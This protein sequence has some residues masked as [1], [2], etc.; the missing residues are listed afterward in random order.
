MSSCSKNFNFGQ[1]VS[2]HKCLGSTHNINFYILKFFVS[3]GSTHGPYES[4]HIIHFNFFKK[5]VQYGLTQSSYRSTHS[6]F[7]R[8]IIFSN[9]WSGSLETWVDPFTYFSFHAPVT[10]DHS[11]TPLFLNFSL[12][13]SKPRLFF[14]FLKKLHKISSFSFSKY[15]LSSSNF[16]FLV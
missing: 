8:K 9:F 12:F 13:H 14:S 4:T 7:K 15:H 16:F 1:C 3:I 6:N 11:F 10:F 5:F 2:T